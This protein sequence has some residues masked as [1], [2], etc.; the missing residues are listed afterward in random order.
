MIV[1]PPT[2]KARFD[3][4]D[5]DRSAEYSIKAVALATGLTVETLRAW[6]RR[7]RVIE[8][9]RNLSGHRVYSS[10]DVS[11]L[12]RLRETVEKGHTIG[13]IAHLSND[14]L[15]GL[16]AVHAEPAIEGSAAEKL[17]SRILQAIEN[18][19]PD[20]CDQCVAMAFALLPLGEVIQ[21][22]L[23]PV[24]RETGVR[25]HRG[26]FSIGQERLI[27]SAVRHHICSL[28]NTYNRV[29]RGATVVFATLSGERHELGI[30]MFAAFAASRA[31]RVAYLGADMPPEEVGAY[32][33]RVGAIA[34]AIS[35]VLSEDK[36][37]PLSQLAML[38][39]HL[40]PSMEIWI[41]GAASLLLDPAGYP[42]SCFNMS[43]FDDFE[44]RVELLTMT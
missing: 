40:L 28:L 23:T 21:N 16:R 43:E 34:V 33:R 35:L 11:R 44:H 42:S 12:R 4:S 14:D 32:A 31:V 41:G 3:M 15:S 6:E 17:V 19:L 25:W 30:L 22:V 29:S 5:G 1:W 20:E 38:R 8:P 7:Y 39:Q 24:L 36:D 13:K 37:T 27:A 9:K 18:F 2:N 26:D 10:S